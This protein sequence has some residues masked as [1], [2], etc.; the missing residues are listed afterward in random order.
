ITLAEIV[1]PYFLAFVFLYWGVASLLSAVHQRR[2][3]S[4]WINLINGILLLVIGFFFI[5]SGYEQ[6]LTMVTFLVSISFIYWGMSLAITSYDLR[7][8]D[9]K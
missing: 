5:S 8:V 3:S 6:N 4:W 2:R 9:N 7:P 1:F